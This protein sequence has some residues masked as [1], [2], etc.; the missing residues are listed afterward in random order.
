MAKKNDRNAACKCN[1]GE[2]FKNCCMNMKLGKNIYGLSRTIP[3]RIKFIVRQKYGFGC[4]ICGTGIIEYEHIDPEYKDAKKHD[5]DC[6]TIL[7]PTCHAKKTRGFLSTE[8]V[9]RAM[10][11]PKSLE[12]GFPKDTLDLGVENFP[13]ILFAGS[14]IE[15]CPIPISINGKPLFEI[16]PPEIDKGSYRL[17]ATFYNSKGEISLEIIN[18]EWISTSDNWDLEV[19]GGKLKIK[20]SQNVQTL[21]LKVVNSDTIEIEQIHS[22]IQNITIVGDKNSFTITDEKGKSNEFS[23]CIFGNCNVGFSIN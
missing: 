11:K 19:T 2:K 18:N 9:K 22:Q 4:I 21:I 7:C 23:N 16:N 10:T 3:S 12:N 20:D 15:N 17:S 8:S 1:S 6:I 13:K 5:P 14:I